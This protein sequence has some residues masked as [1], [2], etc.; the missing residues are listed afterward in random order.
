MH[1]HT[2]PLAP[3]PHHDGTDDGELVVEVTGLIDVTSLESDLQAGAPH[4][5][6]HA[7]HVDMVGL[8]IAQGT[9]VLHRE[10]LHEGGRRLGVPEYY[11]GKG[12]R[13]RSVGWWFFHTFIMQRVN[14]KGAE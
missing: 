1:G 10:R 6:T 11:G 3:P 8:G 2:R 14:K 13:S 12:L 4:A 9:R 5:K 7:V